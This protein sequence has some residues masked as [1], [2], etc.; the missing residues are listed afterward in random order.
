MAAP[1]VGCGVVSFP[2]LESLAHA[3][4]LAAAALLAWMAFLVLGPVACLVVLLLD[5]AGVDLPGGA[6]WIH[7]G[8][9]A[10]W[11]LLLVATVATRSASRLL[12]ELAR[13]RPR[14]GAR[15]RRHVRTVTIGGHGGPQVDPLLAWIWM[16][17]R[18]RE[19][20]TA[21]TRDAGPPRRSGRPIPPPAG[22]SK[23][24][25]RPSVPLRDPHA[26]LG[27][28]HGASPDEIRRAYRA[29]V[30]RHHPDRAAGPSA[31]IRALATR[32]TREIREAYDALRRPAAPPR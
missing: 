2:L 1:A 3:A 29:L 24:A 26:V 8:T 7:V 20:R 31:E 5:L 22:G 12:R 4:A 23:P 13:R 17:A 18:A 28:K 15:P 21:A 32:R 6:S 16:Q 11:A 9:M 30:K 25:P 14:R 27:V 10:S 19:K